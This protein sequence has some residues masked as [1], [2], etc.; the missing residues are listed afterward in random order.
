MSKKIQV[1][2]IKY[3]DFFNSIKLYRCISTNKL[4]YI[5]EC[6][7]NGNLYKEKCEFDI[8]TF[9]ENKDGM[10]YIDSFAKKQLAKQLLEKINRK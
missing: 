2:R 9:K 6:N 10:S 5:G 8:E 7:L 4:K 1:K 3:K